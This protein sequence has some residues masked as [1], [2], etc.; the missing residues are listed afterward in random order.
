MAAERG[1]AK[2]VVIKDVIYITF[3]KIHKI[4]ILT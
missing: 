2:Y 1:C 3:V 4:S